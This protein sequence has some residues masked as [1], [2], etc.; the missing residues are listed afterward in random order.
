LR[1]PELFVV[2]NQTAIDAA[3]KMPA[4]KQAA[5]NSEWD[6]KDFLGQHPEQCPSAYATYTSLKARYGSAHRAY[7]RQVDTFNR[8]GDR[9]NVDLEARRN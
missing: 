9:Y 1:R 5:L 3:N 4:L 8:L 6:Y 2:H 7:N